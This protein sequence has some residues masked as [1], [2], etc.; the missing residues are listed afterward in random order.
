[1]KKLRLIHYVLLV[2]IGISTSS[3]FDIL[4]EYEFNADGSGRARY[5]IDVSQMMDLMSSLSEMD[6][7][8]EGSKSMDDM[9]SENNS[10]IALKTVPGIKN[11]VNLSDKET[12]IVGYS[13]EFESIEALNNALA[14]EGGENEMMAGM[15][16]NMGSEGKENYVSLKGKKFKRVFSFPEEEAK[17]EAEGEEAQYEEMAKMMFADAKYTVKYTFNQGVKK[18]KKNDAAVVGPNKKSVTIEVPFLDLIDH[19]AEVTSEII[20]K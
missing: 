10:V 6:S 15:G 13:Y 14:I 1:M 8:G 18:V 2:L 7:T 3:C 5:T 9:F 19:K 16:M 20:L 12:K 17:D 11:V 4:E